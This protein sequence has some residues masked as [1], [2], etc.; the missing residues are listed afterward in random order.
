MRE[1]AM[2]DGGIFCLEIIIEYRP[3]A[4]L[5]GHNGGRVIAVAAIRGYSSCHQQ[6]VARPTDSVGKVILG[7]VGLDGAVR[8]HELPFL[9]RVG[10]QSLFTL[11]CPEG[12]ARV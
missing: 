7:A 10:T 5:V 1:V 4:V 6:S 11:A 12:A 8:R 2:T 9:E 3:L